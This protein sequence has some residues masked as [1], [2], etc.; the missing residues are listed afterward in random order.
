MK[1]LCQKSIDAGFF[2]DNGSVFARLADCTEQIDTSAAG[3]L[4]ARKILEEGISKFPTSQDITIGLINNYNKSGEDS[5]KVFQ[6]LDKAK[7]NDPTNASLYSFTGEVLSKIGKFE[8]AK[9]AFNDCIEKF[10]DYEWGFIGMGNLYA[11]I[12][13]EVNEKMQDATLDNETYEKLLGEKI[14]AIK[15][16]IEFYE[17]AYDLS[18]DEGLKK[19]LASSLKSNNFMLRDE[20]P[21]YLAAYEKYK[22]LE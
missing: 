15:G 16:C 2:G 11:K 20:D 21:K 17:K 19:N 18:K 8:E 12:S 5:E 7:A 4:A 1:D 9:K 6:L 10:P 14:E 22:A 13:N 3:V